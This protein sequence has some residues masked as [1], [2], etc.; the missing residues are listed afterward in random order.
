MITDCAGFG[1]WDLS[2]TETI[3]V[4]GVFVLLKM[5]WIHVAISVFTWKISRTGRAHQRASIL[6]LE[7]ATSRC[8]LSE[9]ADELKYSHPNEH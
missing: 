2:D 4:Q 3:F 8:G 9:C 5:V 1:Q 6:G 7:E